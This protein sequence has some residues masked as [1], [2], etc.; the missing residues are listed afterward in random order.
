MKETPLQSENASQPRGHYVIIL[1]DIRS[2]V[3][4]T[5]VRLALPLTTS[6]SVLLPLYI[7]YSYKQSSKH[8]E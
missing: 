2:I 5:P 1:G 6:L 7:P 3:F 4:Q 8:L